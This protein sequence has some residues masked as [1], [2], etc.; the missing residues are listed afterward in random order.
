M[1]VVNQYKFKGINN[2]AT[3]N[4]LNIFGTGNPLVSE[5]Y[6][7]K[8]IIVKSAG[9]PTPTVTNDGIVVIQSAALV[10]NQSKE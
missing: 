2:D 5:T 9:T 4:A 6:L 7:I 10:A 3:G 1:A 8:S